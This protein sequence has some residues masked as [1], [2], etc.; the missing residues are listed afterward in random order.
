MPFMV[1]EGA[2]DVITPTSVARRYFDMVQVP[3]KKSIEIPDAEHFAVI[4]HAAQFAMRYCGMSAPLVVIG[5][6][7]PMRSVRG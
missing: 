5:R 1:V 7:S 4:T 3:V 6:S 2:D